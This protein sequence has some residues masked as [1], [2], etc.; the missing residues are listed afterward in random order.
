MKAAIYTRVSQDRTRGGR[1]VAEQEAECRAMCEREH[2][3]VSA[4]YSDND[5]SASRYTSK[6]RPGFER[7]MADVARGTFDVLVIWEASRAT[8]DLG[9]YAKVRDACRAAG[10]RYA[11]NGRVYD[12]DRTD[13]AFSTGLDMLVA[14][15]ESGETSKRIQRTV[16]AQ[17]TA[18]K[19]HGRL[20]YGYTREYDP[21]SGAFI[22]QIPHPD[23]APVIRELADRILTGESLYSISKDLRARGLETFDGHRIHRLL[24]SPTYAGQRVFRG[25]VIGDADWEPLI[26]PEKWESVQG[27]LNAKGRAKFHGAEPV[28]LLSGVAICGVCGGKT[29]RLVNRGK[30]ASYICKDKHCVSRRQDLTDEFVSEVVRGFLS[31]PDALEAINAQAMDQPDVSAAVQDLKELRAR[32]EALYEQAA[33]GSLSA[34]GLARVEGTVLERIAAAEDRLESLRSPARLTIAD[35]AA[36]AARWDSLPLLERRAI[37][38]ELMVVRIM[39][40]RAKGVRWAPESIEI[41]WRVGA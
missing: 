19:P 30:Y 39:P 2:W 29:Q 38:R 27:F 11:Y 41:Q 31:R 26:D 8:R 18:G 6:E 7:L 15:R 5:R 4:V 20:P 10:V 23:E 36:T 25:K 22:R 28:H 9:V 32:L 1:S 13:D 3:T 24:R 35:P 40:A 33:D 12:F 16:R 17:A 14:E 34:A 21:T 37:I